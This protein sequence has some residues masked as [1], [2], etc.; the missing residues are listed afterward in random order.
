VTGTVDVSAGPGCAWTARSNDG[1]ITLTSGTSGNGA[2]VVAFS[3]G[4]HNGN[5]ARTG[6]ATIA[7]H[8]FTITQQGRP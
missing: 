1:W 5:G 7:G 6:T 8:M 2:G 4:D 3:V